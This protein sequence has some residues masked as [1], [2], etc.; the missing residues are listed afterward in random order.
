V[1]RSQGVADPHAGV[2]ADH[3]ELT[4]PL[5]QSERYKRLNH[6]GLLLALY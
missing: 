2:V 4:E 5:V 6:F 3:G 1:I